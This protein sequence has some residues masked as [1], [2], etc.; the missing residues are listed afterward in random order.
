[1]RVLPN[2][3]VFVRVN[4]AQTTNCWAY[5]AEEDLCKRVGEILTV[6]Y[7]KE[8]TNI[9][10]LERHY[11]SGW[12]RCNT[13]RCGTCKSCIEVSEHWKKKNFCSCCRYVYDN[14]WPKLILRCQK[15]QSD[16][17][18]E[19]HSIIGGLGGAVA[20]FR[21]EGYSGKFKVWYSGCFCESGELRIYLWNMD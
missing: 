5:A 2:M 17:H 18:P 10:Y 14:D 12:R 4:A 13:H 3:T 20:E 7:S 16:N 8:D 11:C 21:R 15:I 6:L 9:W 1:M 19:E